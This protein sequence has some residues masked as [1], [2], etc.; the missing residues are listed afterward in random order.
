MKDFRKCEAEK[1]PFRE[2][3]TAEPLEL[4]SKISRRAALVKYFDL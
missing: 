3:R 2:K 4:I 1:C